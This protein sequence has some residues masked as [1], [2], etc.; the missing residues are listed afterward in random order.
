MAGIWQVCGRYS[1]V[2]AER[3]GTARYN[4]VQSGRVRQA[5]GHLARYVHKISHKTQVYKYIWHLIPRASSILKSILMFFSTIDWNSFE[6]CSRIASI[7]IRGDFDLI[8]WN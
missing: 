8:I 6:G 1:Q 2:Q 3:L 7:I 4:Q 5:M